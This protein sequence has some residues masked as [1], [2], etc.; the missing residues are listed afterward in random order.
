MNQNQTVLKHLLKKGRI[1]SLQAIQLYGVTRLASR[2]NDLKQAGWNIQ[3]D[4]IPVIN[5]Y[6]QT[7]YVKQYYIPKGK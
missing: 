7:V 6:G 1:T 5:R 2:I 3:G 4:M